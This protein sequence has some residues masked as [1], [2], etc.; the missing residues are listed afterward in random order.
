[1]NR[2]HI[3]PA[4]PGLE[5][6]RALAERARAAGDGRVLAPALDLYAS[7]REISLREEDAVKAALGDLTQVP[8]W[9]VPDMADDVHDVPSLRRVAEELLGPLPPMPPRKSEPRNTAES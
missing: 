5:D 1:M 9:R 8:V 7:W 4:T 3:V 6:P 2:T